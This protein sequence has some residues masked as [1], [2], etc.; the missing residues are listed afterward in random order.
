MV[1]NVI[2]RTTAGDPSYG[3]PGGSRTPGP[4]AHPDPNR[5][6]EEIAEWYSIKPSIYIELGNEPNVYNPDDDFIWAYRWHLGMAIE[7]CRQVF[8]QAKLI[9]PGL[10]LERKIQDRDHDP[11]HFLDIAHDVM[12]DCDY[13]GVHI[14]EHY[15]FRAAQQPAST[16]QLREALRIYP[17]HFGDKPWYI[18][19]YGINDTR[20]VPTAEKGRRYAGIIHFNE[21]T[22]PLPQNLVGAVYY[23][24]NLKG[25]FHTQYHIYP[26]GDAAY[27]QRIDTA[28]AGGV[29]GEPETTPTVPTI[30]SIPPPIVLGEPDSASVDT[31]SSSLAAMIATLTERERE[32]TAQRAQANSA[33][34][35]LFTAAD[36]IELRRIQAQRTTLEASL[37]CALGDSAEAQPLIEVAARQ[38]ALWSDRREQSQ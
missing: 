30:P 31:F 9:A 14:Y 11:G 33:A 37:S 27:R 2:V 23:H 8:P 7:R 17:A 19:E 21:S 4:E 20:D 10:I 38:I 16:N 36:A 18:T 35:R 15:G 29:L 12:D 5:I 32:M 6:Q 3:Q 22:P 1:P 26:D 25:D 13:I 24:L 28:P 34:G